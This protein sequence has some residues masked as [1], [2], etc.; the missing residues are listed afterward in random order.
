MIIFSILFTDEIRLEHSEEK[1]DSGSNPELS[2][3][4]QSKWILEMEKKI[5]EK[6]NSIFSSIELLSTSSRYFLLQGNSTI[7]EGI[8]ESQSS[9]VL[10]AMSLRMEFIEERKDF[11]DNLVL[12]E[13]L[14]N[15]KV[16]EYSKSQ[17]GENRYSITF[18]FS[19]GPLQLKFEFG[20][21]LDEGL[22]TS[23]FI[24][25]HKSTFSTYKKELSIK[26]LGEDK[27]RKALK[28]FHTAHCDEADLSFKLLFEF[29]ECLLSSDDWLYSY[30]GTAANWTSFEMPS[31]TA[32]S[33]RK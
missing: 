18:Q 24:T 17:S 19:I 7:R 6:R 13:W 22:F 33:A 14:E 23:Y 27:V 32:K 16:E 29:F 3:E 9:K 31:T 15:I 8:S 4:E 12:R 1:K 21:Y 20:G 30:N 28:N 2:L 11:L 5:E 26:N 25:I 10:Q